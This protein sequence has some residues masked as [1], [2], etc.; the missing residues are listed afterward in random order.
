MPAGFGVWYE[1]T[2]YEEG[3]KEGIDCGILRCCVQGE[4]KLELLYCFTA[5]D[6]TGYWIWMKREKRRSA[7]GLP[8]FLAYRKICKTFMVVSPKA[9]LIYLI[10]S[11]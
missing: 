6:E 8:G 9:F 2:E 10:S 1:V 7:G 4:E 3:S 11:V 5:G